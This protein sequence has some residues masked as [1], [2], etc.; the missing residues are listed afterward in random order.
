MFEKNMGAGDRVV[1]FLLGAG[2][3]ASAYIGA[4]G[5]WAY[6]GIIPVIT[7][8]LGSCPAYSIFGFTTCKK[9]S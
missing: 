5:A 6:I 7:S 2:L 4:L 3:I 9:Q 8:A 1:R